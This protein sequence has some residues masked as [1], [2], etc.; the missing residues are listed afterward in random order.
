MVTATG[1][2]DDSDRAEETAKRA[3]LSQTLGDGA[4][5]GQEKKVKRKSKTISI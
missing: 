1:R 5:R 3:G 4:A 2:A